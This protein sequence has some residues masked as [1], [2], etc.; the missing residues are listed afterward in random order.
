[1]INKFSKMIN[2]NYK[3]KKIRFNKDFVVHK[4]HFKHQLPLIWKFSKDLTFKIK[5]KLLI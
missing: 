2:N 3:Y 4:N 1:M 5:K